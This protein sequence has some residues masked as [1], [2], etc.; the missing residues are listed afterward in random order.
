MRAQTTTKRRVYFAL[1]FW[2]LCLTGLGA[3]LVHLQAFARVPRRISASLQRRDILPRRGAIL[4]RTGAFMAVTV[5]TFD[6]AANPREV[7]DRPRAASLL[8]DLLQLPYDEILAKLSQ[9]QQAD[10]SPNYYVLLKKSVGESLARKIQAQSVKKRKKDQPPLEGVHLY[11]RPVR[12]YP[13]GRFAAQLVGYLNA[14]GQGVEGLEFGYNKEL[15][16]VPGYEETKRDA[17]QRPI[18][19][20]WQQIRPPVQGQDVVLTIDE[21]IQFITERALGAA[22][23]R[24]WSLQDGVSER[25]C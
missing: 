10:G 5:D 1:A 14:Q 3:R 21:H 23:D 7:R 15:G 13:M 18:P 25:R 17:K 4:T 11:N 24:Y 12:C 16:G 19:G 6:V 9:V 2:L 20:E 22:A 8:S